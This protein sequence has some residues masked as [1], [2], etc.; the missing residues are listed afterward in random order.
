MRR[1]SVSHAEGN[2]SI[3]CDDCPVALLH[4]E[5]LELRNLRFRPNGGIIIGIQQILWPLVANHFY[6]YFWDGAGAEITVNDSDP[7]RLSIEVRAGASEGFALCESLV[8][9]T[10]EE[11]GLKYRVRQKIEFTE[12]FRFYSTARTVGGEFL[13]YLE[14]TDPYFYHAAGP[15]MEF[16]G[17]W[18]GIWLERQAAHTSRW[19]KK[20]ASTII[21]DESGVYRSF[22]HNHVLIHPP[23]KLAKDGLAL[24]WEEEENPVYRLIGDTA[25]NSILEICNWGYDLHFSFGIPCEQAVTPGAGYAVVRRGERFEAEYEI[26]PMSR[27]LRDEIANNP[28]EEDK[29][30]LE[31]GSLNCPRLV[32]GV[33]SF[34]DGVE[35]KDGNS[36]AWRRRGDGALWSAILGRSD[37]RSLQLANSGENSESS[38]TAF[39]GP[40]FFMEPV[41]EGRRYC[42]TAH[43]T[44]SL[45]EKSAFRAAACFGVAR[46]KGK[47]GETSEVI[48][49]E[50]SCYPSCERW[51]RIELIT[52]PA[53]G[54]ALWSQILFSLK[55]RGEVWIDDVSWT[56]EYSSST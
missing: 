52:D 26:F 31:G 32:S 6:P 24:L 3:L 37:N 5:S 34:S 1:L 12:D 17:F 4:R 46:Y 30:C 29:S 18:T 36:F 41:R 23:L 50:I 10:I 43:I 48:C 22:R 20:W 8:T 7:G 56:Y 14:Y 39:L 15:A 2:L 21:R 45:G 27:A 16:D 38:W 54:D 49:K 13:V 53:P 40:D 51:N 35:Y 42:L 55:G 33:N 11:S 28:P 19:R 9:I 47:S 44:G 25:R